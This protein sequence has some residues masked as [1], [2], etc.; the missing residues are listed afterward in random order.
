MKPFADK[1]STQNDERGSDDTHSELTNSGNIDQFETMEGWNDGKLFG[2]GI[3]S[4]S[5]FDYQSR[6]E[7]QPEGFASADIIPTQYAIIDEESGSMAVPINK[8]TFSTPLAAAISHSKQK[9]QVPQPIDNLGSVNLHS[10]DHH[11]Q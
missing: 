7:R 10:T 2:R 8:S 3:Q 4:C 6:A 1:Y 9:S 11:Q 5:L